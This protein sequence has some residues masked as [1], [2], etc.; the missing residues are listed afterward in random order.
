MTKHKILDQ[1]FHITKNKIFNKFSGFGDF[2]RTFFVSLFIL[3]AIIIS[4]GLFIEVLS[5]H[6]KEFQDSYYFYD[7]I[8]EKNERLASEYVKRCNIGVL[9]PDLAEIC[10]AREFKN[11]REL[12]SQRDDLWAQIEMAQWTKILGYTSIFGLIISVLGLVALHQ[13]LRHTRE[14]INNDRLIGQSQVRAYLSIDLDEIFEFS[15]GLSLKLDFKITNSGQSP[16][17]RVAYC[18]KF[19]VTLNKKS[20]LEF[21]EFFNW[22]DSIKNGYTIPSHKFIVGEAIS[23]SKVSIEEINALIREAE[24]DLY[25][26]VIVKY[27]DVFSLN[28]G[29][30]ERTLK[31]LVRFNRESFTETGGFEI[32]KFNWVFVDSFNM[33]T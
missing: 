7:L 27:H 32:A 30:D 4:W 19:F 33:A 3:W 29:S 14:A 5:F 26:G 20:D 31:F 2:T 21:V 25:L 8:N 22:S 11:Y 23:E 15:A 24:K 18:S 6:K 13:S 17:Y 16:A 28:S 9:P 10:I 1:F 12:L